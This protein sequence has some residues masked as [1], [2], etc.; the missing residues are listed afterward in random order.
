M[1]DNAIKYSDDQPEI[2]IGTKNTGRQI[3]VWIKDSGMG[4]NPKTQKRIFK[5]FY[6]AQT[7]N[8]HKV[9]GFGLGLSYVKLIVDRHMGTIKVDS[10]VGSGTCI[11]ISLPLNV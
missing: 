11:E 1:L 6:R 3:C 9:K 5:K 4:M 10:K 7:G 8:I 2:E